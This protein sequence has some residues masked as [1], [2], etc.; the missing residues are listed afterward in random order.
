LLLLWA[1]LEHIA[2]AAIK[3]MLARR[4]R[5]LQV[6]LFALCNCSVLFPV[7]SAFE[8]GCGWCVAAV[9]AGAVGGARAHR[10]RGYQQDAGATNTLLAGVCIRSVWLFCAYCL[11]FLFGLFR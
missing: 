6:C 3:R 1:V 2:H 4:I 9:L 8:A 10:A 7:W 11:W 5:F